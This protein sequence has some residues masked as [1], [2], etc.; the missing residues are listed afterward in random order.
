M[1]D[2]GSGPLITTLIN[3]G[4]GGCMAALVVWH[5]WF[6]Q[7][8]QLPAMLATF[9][10]QIER[11]RAVSESRITTERQI[12]QMR[13]EENIAQSTLLLNSL[14]ETHHAIQGLANQTSLHHAKID[15]VMG[16]RGAKDGPQALPPSPMRR[17]NPPQ[18]LE[19]Q[20]DK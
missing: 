8:R 18:E 5:V 6:T 17:R 4:V 11:E 1:T 3:F 9:S 15:A 19:E 13:H 12:T 10:A 2:A 20:G 14:R 7:T 16:L